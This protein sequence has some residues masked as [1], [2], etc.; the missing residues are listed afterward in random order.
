MIFVFGQ[1]TK[2][3]TSF[4]VFN[5]RNVHKRVQLLFWPYTQ[6]M[7]ARRGNCLQ[8]TAENPPPKFLGTA[9]AYFVCHVGPNFQISL[10]YHWV[11]VALH[12]WKWGIPKVF[13]KVMRSGMGSVNYKWLAS[14]LL[15]SSSICVNKS[16]LW[17]IIFFFKHWDA[18]IPVY[19]VYSGQ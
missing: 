16:K 13:L 12:E 6:T 3:K 7:D 11:S 14:Y 17:L 2:I 18:F 4:I 8:W 10:T 1:I 9:E 15:I 19:S 5:Q